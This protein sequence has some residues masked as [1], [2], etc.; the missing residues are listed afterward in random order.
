VYRDDGPDL[1][2]SRKYIKQSIG[3]KKKVVDTYGDVLIE[4]SVKLLLR[5]MNNASQGG[6]ALAGEIRQ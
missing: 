5:I 4:Q 3:G 2:Q 1:R 6:E